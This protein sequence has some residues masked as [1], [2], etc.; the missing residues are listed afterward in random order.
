MKFHYVVG[1]GGLGQGV[2]FRFLDNQTLGRNESRLA[3]LSDSKD[4]C[5]GHIILHYVSVFS[6]QHVPVFA[7]GRVGDDRL[8]FDVLSLMRSVGIDCQFVKIDP[9][10]PTMYSVCYMY[11]NGDGGNLTASNSASAMVCPEDID[12]FFLQHGK[13]GRGIVIAA[14]EIPPM[15]RKRLL[16][17][18]RNRNCLLIASLTSAEAKEFCIPEIISNVD[19]LVINQDEAKAISMVAHCSEGKELISSCTEFLFKM[20][21]EMW[22][23]VTRGDAG[24]ECHHLGKRTVFP[25]VPVEAVNTAGAGDCFTGTL[26]AA[27]LHGLALE[28]DD[29]SS[30]AISTALACASMKVLSN[31]SISF[32]INPESLEAFIRERHVSLC[33]E[34]ISAFFGT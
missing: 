33:Q 34:D 30:P 18:G 8:G 16:Q 5:K 31:D 23:I 32:A 15:A 19:I 11:P 9:I 13:S 7:I 6:N 25:A 26:A 24:A 4:Y 1:A 22:I 20:N 17:E 29:G 2:L 3:D 12:E 10:H 28:A 14:P 21:G 27:I